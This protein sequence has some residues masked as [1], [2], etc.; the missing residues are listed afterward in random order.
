VERLPDARTQLP[1]ELLQ[2]VV[3]CASDPGDEVL[4]PFSGS[5]TTGEAC[6]LS[7]RRFT[8]IEKNAERAEWSRLRLRAAL[9]KA[10]KAKAERRAS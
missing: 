9:A 3:G 1:L 7:G 4:D 2:R 6:I 5:G 10:P 8:G